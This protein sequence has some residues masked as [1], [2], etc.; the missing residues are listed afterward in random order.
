MH[1]TSNAHVHEQVFGPSVSH[2]MMG[3]RAFF[4][5]ALYPIDGFFSRHDRQ[6]DLATE[7][8]CSRGRPVAEAQAWAWP[9]V[10]LGSGK[11]TNILC[12]WGHVH[13]RCEDP[14]RCRMQR[15]AVRPLFYQCA[16]EA[17]WQCTP[18]ALTL[19]LNVDPAENRG[20]KLI[21]HK[22]TP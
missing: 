3:F 5:S 13:N 11:A 2:N 12:T 1:L 17:V 16:R 15:K 4:R 8:V 21:G 14:M 22:R 7:C 9:A 19:G 18:G 6:N 10:S 20:F